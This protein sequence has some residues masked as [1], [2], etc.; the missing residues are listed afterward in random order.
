MET[1]VI[2]TSQLVEAQMIGTLAIGNEFKFSDNQE[3]SNNNI[4]LYA[5]QAYSAAQ[6]SK[7]PISQNT[8]VA[9]AGVPS[10][11]VTF[12]DDTN[13]EVVQNIPLYDIIRSNNGGFYTLVKPLKVNLTKC[14]IKLVNTTSVNANEVV[15]F[16]FIYTKIK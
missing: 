3:I 11:A 7:S 9:A 6:L 16:N 14:Y 12:V 1:A 4:L 15:L 10:V 5:L 8:V 2:K 13:T